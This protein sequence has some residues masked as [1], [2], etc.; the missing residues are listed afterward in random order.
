MEGKEITMWTLIRNRAL[1]P[2]RRM[3]YCCDELKERTGEEG[4][5]IFNGVR[6]EESDSRSKMPMINFYKGKIMARIIIDWLEEDVWEI[7]HKYNIPYCCKYDEGWKRIGCIGCPLGSGQAKELGE[8]P[9]F[10]EAY[11]RAFD[12]MLNYRKEN[13]METE[14]KTGEEVYKWWIG[15]CTKQNRVVKG[16]CSMF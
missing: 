7:I 6:A 15:E 13:G 10:K 5:T 8:Y 14:W 9:K 1:P 4:D 12:D 11:I 3:R 16:Q 2:T